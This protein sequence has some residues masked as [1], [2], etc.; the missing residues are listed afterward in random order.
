MRKRVD[1]SSLFFYQCISLIDDAGAGSAGADF[2]KKLTFD[3]GV[4]K[5]DIIWYIIDKIRKGEK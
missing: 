5:V 1:S 4:D 2:V 3:L